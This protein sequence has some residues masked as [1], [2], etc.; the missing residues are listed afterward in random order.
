MSI[1]IAIHHE[2]VYSYDR[3]VMLSPHLIRLHPAAHCFTTVHSYR[4]DV[5]PETRFLNWQQDPLG[6]LVAR[7]VFPELV[8]ELIIDM[9]MVVDIIVA[10]PF[11]FFVE[12]YAQH[13]PFTYEA[14]TARDLSPY[15][16]LSEDGPLLQRYLDGISRDRHDT[17]TFLV[18]LNQQL[19]QHIAY[20]QRLEPGVQSCEQT[21][22]SA[23]GSC[24]DSAWLLVQVLRHLGLAA[25]FVSGYLVELETPD[26]K[27]QQDTTALHAWTEVFIP[28]AG[29]MGLDPTSGLFASEGHIP[30]CCTSEPTSAAPVTGFTE[31]CK[32]RFHFASTVTRLGESD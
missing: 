32:T 20:I 1:R 5:R 30:L 4:L 26:A 2:T 16:G 11:N 3:E 13:W 8:R 19:Q 10:N 23:A 6:N 27:S 24:R 14:S 15:F 12:D 22:A 29:W 17:V 21:L 7:C 31:A 28:G 18:Q 9:E 25:R